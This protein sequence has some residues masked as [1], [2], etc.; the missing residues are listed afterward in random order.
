MGVSGNWGVGDYFLDSGPLGQQDHIHT[1]GRRLNSPDVPLSEL[2][3]VI[4]WDFGLPLLRRW[5]VGPM[6]GKKGIH[7]SLQATGGPVE[8]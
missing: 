8:D 3:A 2:D 5:K 4:G 1:S 7:R 6:C